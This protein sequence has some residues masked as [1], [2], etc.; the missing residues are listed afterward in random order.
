MLEHTPCHRTP[1]TAVGR[2]AML[3]TLLL[4]LVAPASS[5]RVVVFETVGNKGAVDKQYMRR[6]QR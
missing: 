6:L 3:A 1:A 2:W 5:S 4:A